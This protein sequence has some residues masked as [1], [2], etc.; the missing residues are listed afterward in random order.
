MI[1][2]YKPIDEHIPNSEAAKIV[3]DIEITKIKNAL[4]KQWDLHKCVGILS[5]TEK[6]STNIFETFLLFVLYFF[7][8]LSKHRYFKF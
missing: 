1:V 3:E 5:E 2:Q 7:I 4:L 6:V 8:V